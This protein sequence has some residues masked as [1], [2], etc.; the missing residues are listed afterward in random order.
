[1]LSIFIIIHLMH[2]VPTN[3]KKLYQGLHNNNLET[4]LLIHIE[5]RKNAKFYFSCHIHFKHW[6]SFSSA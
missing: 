3:D 4:L 5:E 6:T 1:M 2:G